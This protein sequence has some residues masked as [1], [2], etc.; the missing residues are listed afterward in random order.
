MSGLDNRDIQELK[1]LQ[2]KEKETKAIA[3]IFELEETLSRCGTADGVDMV[4]QSTKTR[5]RALYN[6]GDFS[7]SMPHLNDLAILDNITDRLAG[8][9]R[10]GIID[11]RLS[12]TESVHAV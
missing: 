8:K 10:D 7:F 6:G 4:L 9:F 2:V 12:R 11:E 1:G 5:I 3:E